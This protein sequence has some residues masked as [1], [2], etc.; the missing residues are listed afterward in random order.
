LSER[1]ALDLKFLEIT[2][3][4][5]NAQRC[6]GKRAQRMS[7]QLGIWTRSHG[8]ARQRAFL[9]AM[10]SR[11]NWR[12]SEIGDVWAAVMVRFDKALLQIG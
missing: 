3:R 1:R 12:Q 4:Q 11:L 9:N 6:F 7:A 5:S 2:N 8:I 10:V